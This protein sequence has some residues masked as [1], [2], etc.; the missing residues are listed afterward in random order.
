M[1]MASTGDNSR[2]ALIAAL[3]GTLAD[4]LAPYV[5][6]KNFHWHVAGPR[7]RD[8][9]L[10]FDEQA[11]QLIA[12]VDLIGE[13][14]RKN[15]AATLTSIG[16]VAGGTVIANQDNTSLDA[17]TMVAELMA[18]NATLLGRLRAVKQ[19]AEEASDYATSGAVDG[20]IDEA[21][22]RVWFLGQ[23]LK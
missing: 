10:M 11:A 15:G 19:A 14:V 7:F 2:A 8:L 13:R 20:W 23:V 3:N 18:D 9:H 22:E 6:T 21:E 1:T 17:D 12:Q 4:Y 16:A 5:K